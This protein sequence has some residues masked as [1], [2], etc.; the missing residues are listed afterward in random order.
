[1]NRIL[2]F[3]PRFVLI[4]HRSKSAKLPNN[5]ELTMTKTAATKYLGLKPDYTKQ[6]VKDAFLAKAKVVH[7]DVQVV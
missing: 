6:D 7:P 1:M 3:R 4:T 2:L 5:V